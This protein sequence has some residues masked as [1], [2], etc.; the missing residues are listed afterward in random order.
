MLDTGPIRPH[1]HAGQA[2]GVICGCTMRWRSLQRNDRQ[3]Q[4]ARVLLVVI[5]FMHHRLT[6]ANV[7]WRIFDVM[8]AGKSARQIE[9]GDVEANAMAGFEQIA[10]R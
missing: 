3:H 5:D 7:I 10:R 8:R 6:A 1:P 4:M 2:R 9:A